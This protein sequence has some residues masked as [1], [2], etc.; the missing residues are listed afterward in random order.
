M[1]NFEV[2]ES[3]FQ[4]TFK[5]NGYTKVIIS[6]KLIV[7]FIEKMDKD[8]VLTD[9]QKTIIFTAYP[10]KGYTEMRIAL[11]G[12]RQ[13][14]KL[15]DS[16]RKKIREWYNKNVRPPEEEFGVEYWKKIIKAN[17]GKL[18]MFS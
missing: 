10:G 4:Y 15:W 8:E 7:E 12:K 18:P 6:K 3:K 11:N 2:E 14:Y 5:F 13:S 16:E 9:G 17:G 1:T